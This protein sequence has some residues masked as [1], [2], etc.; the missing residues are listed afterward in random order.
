MSARKRKGDAGEAAYAER[1]ELEGHVAYPLSPSFPTADLL[2]LRSDGSI[3]LVEV[4]TWA[5][6][7]NPETIQKVTLGL[8]ALRSMMPPIQRRRCILKL[9][10][11]VKG[12]DGAYR[13][14]ETW[15]FP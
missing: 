8:Y 13:F 6:P 7:L 12:E 4:K 1:C 9:V 2:V 14:A 15:R 10:H 11:A 3:E 5:R